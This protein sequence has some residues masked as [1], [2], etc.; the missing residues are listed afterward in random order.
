MRD[1]NVPQIYSIIIGSILLILC[2]RNIA[3]LIAKWIKPSKH[4][5]LRFL[6]RRHRLF[7][8]WSQ[9]SVLIHLFYVVVNVLL[10]LLGDMTLTSVH[11]RAGDIAVVNMIILL[12]FA[13]LSFMADT[14]G[15]TLKISQRIHSSVGRMT[16][17]LQ[18]LHISLTALT[19]T[20]DVSIRDLREFSGIL[21]C[22]K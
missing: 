11:R 15:M 12:S 21:V 8:P 3:S 10:V 7:G 4:L 9:A 13:H 22:L 18:A 16:L 1:L 2:F 5:T 6:V 17:A 14:L 19:T 20:F